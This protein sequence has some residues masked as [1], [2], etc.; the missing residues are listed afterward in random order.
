MY[1]A[2]LMYPAPEDVVHPAAGDTRGIWLEEIVE[3]LP[4][5]FETIH[6][7]HDSEVV[8]HTK[9]R[10]HLSHNTCQIDW[11]NSTRPE[12]KPCP[13]YRCELFITDPLTAELI[14]QM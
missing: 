11:H 3:S 6:G 10:R 13:I 5:Y 7:P 9:P 14:R 2:Q 1:L 8:V 4:L 12:R